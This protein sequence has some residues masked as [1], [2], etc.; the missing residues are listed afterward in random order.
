MQID[1]DPNEGRRDYRPEILIYGAIAV[2][3]Y[4]S[5]RGWPVRGWLDHLAIFLFLCLLWWLLIPSRGNALL[6]G[7]SHQNAGN[8]IAFRLGKLLNR[9]RRGLRG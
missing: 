2:P 8:G 4:V 9:V 7:H 1:H 5:T 3:L 6:D